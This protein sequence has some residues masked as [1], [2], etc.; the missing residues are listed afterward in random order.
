MKSPSL[1][2]VADNGSNLRNAGGRCFI[3][4]D[5]HACPAELDSLLKTLRLQPED[6]LV[7]LGDYI[8]RGPDARSVVDL[9]LGLRAA[10]VCHC[11]FLKG[12]HEDMFL[13]FLGL[14]GLYGRSFLDNGGQQTLVSYGC[15]PYAARV[16]VPEW[17]PDPHREFFLN[18]KLGLS[19]RLGAGHLSQDGL[20]NVPD[21]ALR[22]AVPT[23]RQAI[24][25]TVGADFLC[26]H[27]GIKPGVN[28]PD[29]VPEDLLWIREDFFL[30]PHE[31]PYTIVY[32]HTPRRE[33]G[34]DLPYKVGIDTGLVYG[35]RLSCLEIT[36]KTLFQ[37]SL[38]SRKV[39]KSDVRGQWV[40]SPAAC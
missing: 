36:E 4:G 24:S 6:Y 3:I 33:V 27:A 5:I 37:V 35:G 31:L 38:G 15:D 20:Q 32:G 2:P 39:E 28:L 19:V 34:F 30:Y 11:T 25:H 29:Q 13:D 23:S 18:L 16:P 22:Q 8:D 26:V 14:G 21:D 10:A 1:S 9:L 17:L 7:C 12:N 40:A